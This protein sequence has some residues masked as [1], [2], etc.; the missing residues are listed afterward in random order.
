MLLWK[1]RQPVSLAGR[2]VLR[3]TDDGQGS[4]AV[5]TLKGSGRLCVVQLPACQAALLNSMPWP[6]MVHLFA[7]ERL[8]PTCGAASRPAA[9]VGQQPSDATLDSNKPLIGH[10]NHSG[11]RPQAE[12]TPV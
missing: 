11:Q 6:S 2:V 3:A 1:E 10:I 9:L 8:L 4:N 7:G 12:S 5:A